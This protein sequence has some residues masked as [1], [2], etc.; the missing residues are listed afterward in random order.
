MLI[1]QELLTELV[2][3]V[4][5]EGKHQSDPGGGSAFPYD[6]GVSVARIGVQMRRAC[7][8]T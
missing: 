3:I 8:R 2:N 4:G 7:L 1:S 5:L 6:L